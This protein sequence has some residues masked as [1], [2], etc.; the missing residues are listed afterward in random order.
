MLITIVVAGILLF[1][2]WLALWILY[3]VGW[4]KIPKIFRKPINANDP[5]AKPYK[6]YPSD[7]GR[8]SDPK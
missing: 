2:V 1:D 4:I 8:P 6:A 7:K 5:C 3:Q